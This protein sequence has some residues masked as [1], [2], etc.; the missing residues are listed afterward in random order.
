MAF[1]LDAFVAVAWAFADE[2]HRAAA[3]ALALI[4]NDEGCV[5]SLW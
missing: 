2:T 4:R 5:P 3:A 1:V